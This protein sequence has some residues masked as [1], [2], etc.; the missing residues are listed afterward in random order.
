MI[1]IISLFFIYF[2]YDYAHV[3]FLLVL[4]TYLGDRARKVAEKVALGTAKELKKAAAE[5]EGEVEGN[6]QT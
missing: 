4:G 5:H 1:L 2:I 6:S 3:N